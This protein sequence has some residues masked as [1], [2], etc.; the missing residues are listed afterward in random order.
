MKK[1]SRRDRNTTAQTRADIMHIVDKVWH[2]LPGAINFLAPGK[3]VS[4]ESYLTEMRTTYILL[5]KVDKQLYEHCLVGYN[6]SVEELEK[7]I[8]KVKKLIK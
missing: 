7:A 8:I 2:K 3:M 6:E 1:L 4:V 5:T